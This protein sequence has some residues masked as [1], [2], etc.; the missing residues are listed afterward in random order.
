MAGEA[1]RLLPGKMPNLRARMRTLV[2]MRAGLQARI[3]AEQARPMP[4]TLKIQRLKR[5]R[6]KAKDETASIEGVLRTLE[7]PQ[8]PA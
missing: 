6:L 1:N 2:S 5:K 4:D 3:D 8:L 7:R